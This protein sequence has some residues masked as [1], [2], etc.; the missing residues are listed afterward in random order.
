MSKLNEDI[1]GMD[2]QINIMEQKLNEINQ[3]P[4]FTTST[5]MELYYSLESNFTSC[6]EKLKNIKKTSEIKYFL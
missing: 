6:K 5:V 2:T 1:T 4:E 3:R